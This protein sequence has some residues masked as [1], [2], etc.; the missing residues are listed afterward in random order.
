MAKIY[1]KE[2]SNENQKLKPKAETLNFI[3]N[4]S[5]VIDIIKTENFIIQ[6]SKN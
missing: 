6:I 4:Y 1:S 5:K 3:L 2:T